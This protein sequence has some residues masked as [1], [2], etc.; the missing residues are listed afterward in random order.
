VSC[1]NRSD[2][3]TS[4]K[5]NCNKPEQCQNHQDYLKSND[6]VNLSISKTDN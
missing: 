3:F 1:N 2:N 4:W 6:I 5:F